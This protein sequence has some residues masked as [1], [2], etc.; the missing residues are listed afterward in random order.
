MILRTILQQSGKCPTHIDLKDDLTESFTHTQIF[1][2][3]Q[4]NFHTRQI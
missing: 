4:A 1:M 2:P 3:T